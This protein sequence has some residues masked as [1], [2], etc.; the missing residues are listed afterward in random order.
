MS[1]ISSLKIILVEFNTVYLQTMAKYDVPRVVYVK[2][3]CIFCFENRYL[4][5]NYLCTMYI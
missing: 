4:G 3:E 2:A 5:M 1:A